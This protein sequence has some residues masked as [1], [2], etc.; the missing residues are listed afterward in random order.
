M[1][2]LWIHLTSDDAP[3]II[4]GHSDSDGHVLPL[5]LFGPHR[6]V[7]VIGL[8]ELVGLIRC[9]SSVSQYHIIFAMSGFIHYLVIL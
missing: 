9:C 2:R 5:D 6:L 8:T 3:H 7:V 4:D 1:V